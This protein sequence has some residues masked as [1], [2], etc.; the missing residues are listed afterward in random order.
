MV[1]RFRTP[2][3]LQEESSPFVPSREDAPVP[4]YKR[5][6]V[7]MNRSRER[8]GHLFVQ[9]PSG[10]KSD[11]LIP[12]G[13]KKKNTHEKKR[14]HSGRPRRPGPAVT[15]GGRLLFSPLLSYQSLPSLL[16]RDAEQ[17]HHAPTR[18]KLPLLLSVQLVSL[19]K[20][21]MNISAR[22]T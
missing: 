8:T 22:G 19:H 14:T 21:S 3:N 6:S 7:R 9:V 1:R 17:H 10:G 11:K 5:D 18:R 16:L 15:Q 2:E 12:H 4:L 20:S 13:L